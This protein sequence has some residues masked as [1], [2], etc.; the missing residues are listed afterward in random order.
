MVGHGAGI[1]KII[2]VRE[3]RA[4]DTIE[5]RTN[6]VRAALLGIMAGCALLEN[7]LAFTKVGRRQHGKNRFRSCWCAWRRS[8][9][10][11]TRHQFFG[12]GIN[13]FFQFIGM[14]KCATNLSDNNDQKH[15][16]ND[17]GDDLVDFHRVHD[18]TPLQP[19]H[20]QVFYI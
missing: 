8:R 6:L 13:R 12:E 11:G 19:N 7:F 9:R 14:D 20:S 17:A 1:G 18:G 2:L 15:G 5:V 10:I 3:V 16:T 4:N